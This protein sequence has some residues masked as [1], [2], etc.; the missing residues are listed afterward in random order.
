MDM[1]AI[2]AA[3]IGHER[4]LAGRAEALRAGVE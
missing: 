1:R 3:K 2:L 4:A